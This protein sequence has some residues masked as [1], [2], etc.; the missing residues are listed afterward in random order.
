MNFQTNLDNYNIFYEVAKCQSI[1]K[2]SEK[3]FISQPAV[4]Q[5]IK[6]MEDNLG[7]TLFAREKK[8]I[9]LTSIGRTIFEEVEN[10]LRAIQTAEQHIDEAK[11]VLRGKITIGSGSNIAR[12]LLC[13][14]IS[15]FVEKYPQI[16]IKLVENTQD[17]MIEQLKLGEI[18]LVLTQQNEN[19]DLPFAPLYEM[20][21]CFV[22]NPDSK[23]NKLISI[24]EGSFA[25]KLIEDFAKESDL[26]KDDISLFV[27]GYKTALEFAKLGMG[28]TLVPKYLAEKEIASGTL[29]EIYTSYQLPKIT[30]GIYH[31]PSL[32]MP[33][34]KMFLKELRKQ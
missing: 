1:T 33:I 27:S 5:A 14:P 25:N 15:S 28:T 3:L 26:Q 12:Q 21:Y 30:F 32:L 16:S 22:K 19:I 8:G 18:D 31:N 4:S 11:G 20:E 9:K 13:K 17:K 2:A 24:S 34:G 23:I 10:A 6:K 7:A 29:C